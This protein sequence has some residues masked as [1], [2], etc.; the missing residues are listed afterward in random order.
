M[1]RLGI[2]G[3]VFLLCAS[4][5]A[6]VDWRYKEKI[7]ASNG[8]TNDNF[9][10]DVDVDGEWAVVGAHKQAENAGAA[11]FHQW[12]GTNWVERDRVAASDG[13]PNDGFGQAVALSGDSAIVGATRPIFPDFAGKAYVFVRSG[14]TWTEQAALTDGGQFSSFGE[15]ADIDGDYAIVGARL[16]TNAAGVGTGAAHVFKRTG[17]LWAP[18]ATLTPSDG[19]NGDWFGHAVAI[20]DPYAIVGATGRS[21]F[22]GGAY[23]FHRSGT[24]WSEVAVLNSPDDDLNDFFGGAVDIS[25]G[26]AIVGLRHDGFQGAYL[27]RLDGAGWLLHT[28]LPDIYGRFD[29]YGEDVALTDPYAV[30]GGGE[31]AILWKRSGTNWLKQIYVGSSADDWNLSD[32]RLAVHRWNILTGHDDDDALGE[33]AGAA[34]MLPVQDRNRQS[35]RIATSR[36][37]RSIGSGVAV[38]GERALV[39]AEGGSVPQDWGYAG[40]F[41]H[42]GQYWLSDTQ[43]IPGDDTNGMDFG[44]GAALAGDYAAVGAK[45]ATNGAGGKVGAAYVYWFDGTNWLQ[46]AKLTDSGE[47]A[48]QEFGAAIETDGRQV[49]VG[50]PFFDSADG[51][52]VTYRRAGTNWVEG[53]T[54]PDPAMDTGQFGWDIGFDGTRAIF[55][56]PNEYEGPHLGA[57]AAYI[58]ATDGTNWNF[59][60]RIAAAAPSFFMQ[61]GSAVDIDDDWAACGAPTEDAPT[62]QFGAVHLFQRTGATWTE[63]LRIPA[64]EPFTNGYFGSAVAL[65]KPYLLA[66][67]NG[68]PASRAYIFKQDGTNWNLLARLQGGDLEASEA[69]GSRCDLSDDYAIVGTDVQEGRKAYLFYRE[70]WDPEPEFS[71]IRESSGQV[72]VDMARLIL[73]STTLVERARTLT[74]PGAWTE[75]HRFIPTGP[76]SNWVDTVTPG[77][78]IFYRLRCNPEPLAGP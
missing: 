74:D 68:T 38:D 73:D 16:G 49:L 15:A 31:H 54:L 52:V 2:A 35:G 32:T 46:Q 4:F 55:G 14:T 20:D 65:K 44:S 75:Q 24:V 57:G 26:W 7:T 34:W 77:T 42:T 17:L 48:D 61:L 71:A 8:T 66:C 27:Y 64:P 40:V 37:L 43:L 36:G 23:L 9:G 50:A 53:P 10:C 11:Y 69:F 62:N 13:A 29:F 22:T 19:A 60:Q 78:G 47:E 41:V 21:N 39:G 59:E 1:N 30:V 3:L 51:K 33:N 70:A 6:A 76:E 58:Y 72:R 45:G 5:A 56:A 12:D 25:G 67:A 28:G 18:E 63:K